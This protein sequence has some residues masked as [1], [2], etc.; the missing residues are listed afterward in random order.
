MPI[1]RSKTG[2][3]KV[4]L[5]YISFLKPRRLGGKKALFAN[6]DPQKKKKN[7]HLKN[8]FENVDDK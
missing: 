3:I 7:V 1:Y 5:K 4:N 6:F 8:S 2:D